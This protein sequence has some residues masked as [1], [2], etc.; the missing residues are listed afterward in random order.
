MM[1][2]QNRETNCTRISFLGGLY[3]NYESHSSLTCY[4]QEQSSCLEQLQDLKR[5]SNDLNNS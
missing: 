5:K 3:T 4:S 2:I 1:V